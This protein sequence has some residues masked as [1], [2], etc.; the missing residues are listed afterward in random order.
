MH[1][2]WLT[3]LRVDDSTAT[4]RPP[5]VL[6]PEIV[7][8]ASPIEVAFVARASVEAPA[9]STG[10][11]VHARMLELVPHC[12]QP[13]MSKP[14]P[15]LQ[16]SVPPENPSDVHVAPPRLVPSQL[17]AV[18]VQQL[19]ASSSGPP[20]PQG[21]QTGQESICPLPQSDAPQMPTGGVGV[22]Q[23]PRPASRLTTSGRP[24]SSAA[25]SAS[26]LSSAVSTTR[27]STRM[28]SG[29]ESPGT[30]FRAESL[31]ASGEASGSPRVCDPPHAA[32]SA[33][34]TDTD[35]TAKTR[36]RPLLDQGG[37]P[38]RR[39]RGNFAV[40]IMSG[41]RSNPRAIRAQ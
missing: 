4:W 21:W 24:T 27:E 40:C 36:R 34:A 12:V 16:R 13:E 38:G 26:V 35:M 31:P 17:S 6:V 33:E 20:P 7:T 23:T 9:A 37:T 32:H 15:A 14:Q 29:P 2:A 41:G 10:A 25:T 8:Q 30:S 28:T 19:P 39:T 1:A 3:T 22:G 5:A 18:E 11:L